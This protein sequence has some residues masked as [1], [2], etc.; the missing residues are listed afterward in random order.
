[1]PGE[2]RGEE[3]AIMKYR[4]SML[5][6]CLNLETEDGCVDLLRNLIGLLVPSK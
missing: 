1:M 2:M 4:N 3:S 6:N 5:I